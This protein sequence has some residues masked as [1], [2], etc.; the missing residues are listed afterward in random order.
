MGQMAICH[1]SLVSWNSRS[2]AT[3]GSRAKVMEIAIR[4][5]HSLGNVPP[6]LTV[7]NFPLFLPGSS[8]M[9]VSAEQVE[10]AVVEFYRDPVAKGG[11]N[12]WLMQ[13]Q[14]SR[15]SWTFAWPLLDQRKVTL[16]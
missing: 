2:W 13:A 15:H 10:Q 9:E 8:K 6:L 3:A 7:P 1:T 11:L 5:M 14:H 16:G 4:T 12:T